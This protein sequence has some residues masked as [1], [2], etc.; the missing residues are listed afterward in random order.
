[1]QFKIDGQPR[2]FFRNSRSTA[3]A[4]LWLPGGQAASKSAAVKGMTRLAISGL[5]R[6]VVIVEANEKSGALITA[7]HAAE[8]GREVFAVP[9][10]VD[11]PAS[12]G[13]L[14]LLRQGAKLVR[15][16][17]DVLED[18]RGVA[19][20]VAAGPTATAPATVRT[21]AP[22]PGLD[23][24]Q[25][26]AWELL[27]EGPCHIDDMARRLSL[28]V[29]DLGG[30]LMLLEMKKVVRRLPGNHYERR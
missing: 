14:G 28:P 26:R 6:A 21:D 17:D 10:P 23:E 25:L 5:A 11:S 8:Q 9:G 3:L 18:L 27:A 15:H 7:H 13:T 29:A 16:A 22:P 24:G 2:R 30:T 12:A 19:P 20:L 1:M 4:R